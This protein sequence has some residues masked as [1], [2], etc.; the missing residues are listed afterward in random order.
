M[1]IEQQ[2]L[3]VK[4]F[5]APTSEVLYIKYDPNDMKYLYMCVNCSTSWQGNNDS[6]S[7]KYKTLF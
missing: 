3:S 4:D 7:L 1:Q 2:N 5:D 6:L